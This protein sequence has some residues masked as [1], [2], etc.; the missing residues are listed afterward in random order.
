MWNFLLSFL[1]V[2]QNSLLSAGRM[3]F[4][5]IKS[6]Q[7]QKNLDQFL[8]YKKANLGPVLTLQHMCCRVIY[9]YIYVYISPSLSLDII[10]GGGD[11]TWWVP[12][13]QKFNFPQF[14]SKNGQ[15]K[16][17]IC[18]VF[19]CF[20]VVSSFFFL[21]FFALV[22]LLFL[23]FSTSSSLKR[24]PPSGVS[25]LFIYIWLHIYIYICCRVKTWSKNS[26]FLSQNLVQVF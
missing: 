17:Q 22:F 3:I 6:K 26:L 14:Y 12:L 23:C 4:L 13:I 11:P 8:A 25:G 9:I 21:L 7:I 2:F 19:S 16:T 20:Q 15:E 24:Y 18:G 10:Y 1:L 5:K